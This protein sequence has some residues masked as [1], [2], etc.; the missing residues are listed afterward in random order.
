MLLIKNRAYRNRDLDVREIL[1][2][3]EIS[4]VRFIVCV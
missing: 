3:Y 2:I 4:G 1:V